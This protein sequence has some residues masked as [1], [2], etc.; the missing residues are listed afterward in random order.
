MI[1]PISPVGSSFSPVLAST[2]FESVSGH[3]MP[4]EPI[5]TVFSV[6]S[7]GLLCVTGE[8]SVRP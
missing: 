2:I 8:V 5:F 3:G 7:T 6:G 4:M 1:S